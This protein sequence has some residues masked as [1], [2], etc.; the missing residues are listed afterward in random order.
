MHDDPL[1]RTVRDAAKQIDQRTLEGMGASAAEELA[2]YA[3]LAQGIENFLSRND[4]RLG[5]LGKAVGILNTHHHGELEDALRAN[6]AFNGWIDPDPSYSTHR[7]PEMEIVLFH[8]CR[9]KWSG[10]VED[11]RWIGSYRNT[12]PVETIAAI[13]PSK[14][15]QFGI[16][17]E[18]M[19]AAEGNQI[20]DG[21]PT[22][23]LLDELIVL[24]KRGSYDPF[25]RDD[26]PV[27]TPLSSEAI[28]TTLSKNFDA[29][30]DTACALIAKHYA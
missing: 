23:E 11:G 21:Q 17:R 7:D 14:G 3:H 28:L 2:D 19:G 26:C 29:L 24:T 10:H 27:V 30:Y 13:G 12:S 6:P 20:R 1:A 15:F 22:K 25:S 8:G 18:L 4:A 5:S 16:T 9:D